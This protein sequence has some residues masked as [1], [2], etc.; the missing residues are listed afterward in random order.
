MVAPPKDLWVVGLKG[1]VLFEL[2]DDAGALAT[3]QAYLAVGRDP[4]QR[5]RDPED[6]R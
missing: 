1:T 2:H 4:S 5:E 6:R 3:Y